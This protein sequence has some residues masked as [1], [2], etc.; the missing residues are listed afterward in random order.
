MTKKNLKMLKKNKSLTIPSDLK[1]I[2]DNFSEKSKFKSTIDVESNEA[3]KLRGYNL[4]TSSS[5]K[6]ITSASSIPLKSMRKVKS[7]HKED[8]ESYVLSQIIGKKDSHENQFQIHSPISKVD[9]TTEMENENIQNISNLVETDEIKINSGEM[10]NNI[11]SFDGEKDKEKLERND[12]NVNND[13]PF[14]NKENI[15]H[16]DA[17]NEDIEKDSSTKKVPLSNYMQVLYDQKSERV[18]KRSQQMRKMKEKLNIVSD[19]GNSSKDANSKKSTEG[20]TKVP[21]ST[22]VFKEKEEIAKESMLEQAINSNAKEIKNDDTELV[23][24]DLDC[25]IEEE[26]SQNKESNN[27]HVKNSLSMNL[28]SSKSFIQI[29]NNLLIKSHARENNATSDY[30]LALNQCETQEEEIEKPD[31]KSETSNEKHKR[32]PSVRL[33]TL[34]Y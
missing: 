21:S 32:L 19:A 29:T 7:F 34:T 23:I 1:K 31:N 4:G 3:H 24:S 15:I 17:E 22:K 28:P 14:N 33:N 2:N 5:F 13:I 20:R 16:F 18:K 10:T 8:K 27:G 12:K 25:P 26:V 11:T 6:E 30:L 9:R